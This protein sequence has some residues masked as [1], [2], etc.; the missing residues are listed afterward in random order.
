MIS[1]VLKKKN[2]SIGL[3]SEHFRKKIRVLLAVE[4][5]TLERFF[6]QLSNGV[7]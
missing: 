6:S 2:G 3:Q 4:G 1:G 7:C 5:S